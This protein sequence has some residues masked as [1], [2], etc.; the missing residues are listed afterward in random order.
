MYEILKFFGAFFKSGTL[1]IYAPTF[2]FQAIDLPAAVDLSSLYLIN[3]HW[4]DS[5]SRHRFQAYAKKLK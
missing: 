1:F 5:D 2:L 3:T 4:G